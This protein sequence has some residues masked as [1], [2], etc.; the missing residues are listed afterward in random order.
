MLYMYSSSKRKLLLGNV[1]AAAQYNDLVYLTIDCR[2]H[3]Y[4]ICC[5]YLFST[6]NESAW[7]VCT[8]ARDICI[9]NYKGV[10]C[11]VFLII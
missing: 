8:E 6:T 9:H 11:C 2:L 5:V 10:V 1:T 7:C 4:F 3:V